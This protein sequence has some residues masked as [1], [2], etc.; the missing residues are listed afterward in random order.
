[1]HVLPKYGSSEGGPVTAFLGRFK[2]FGSGPRPVSFSAL[3]KN[4]HNF[5][6]AWECLRSRFCL[7]LTGKK[8]KV[9]WVTELSRHSV[10]FHQEKEK[11]RN[12]ENLQ[13][14]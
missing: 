11:R 13:R 10:I 8:S 7:K 5:I 9:G 14:N 12:W 2:K 4:L 1:M 3:G 6:S